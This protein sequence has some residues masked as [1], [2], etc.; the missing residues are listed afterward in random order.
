M[1][2][3]IEICTE[4]SAVYCR[5][6]KAGSEIFW[7]CILPTSSEGVGL[8]LKGF[9]IGNGK[10]HGVVSSGVAKPGPGRA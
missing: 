6:W 4:P 9:W 7:W 2:P 5:I 3:G 10:Y 1:V 8:Y